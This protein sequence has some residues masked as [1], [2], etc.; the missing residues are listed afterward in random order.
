MSKIRRPSKIVPSAE[1][2]GPKA[3][4]K[5][6]IIEKINKAW[7][8]PRHIKNKPAPY[9]LALTKKR[10]PFTGALLGEIFYLEYLE[11]STPGGI[12]TPSLRFRRTVWPRL[13]G[14]K[15]PWC[16]EEPCLLVLSCNW[17]VTQTCTRAAQ[18]TAQF[19]PWVGL[20]ARWH[21]CVNGLA[22]GDPRAL[23]GRA[24]SSGFQI[25]YKSNWKII[26]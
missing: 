10:A 18:F 6:I 25:N 17:N 24:R 15:R 1:P 5:P 2:S 9:Y 14:R 19:F 11:K 21:S 20:R 4:P 23:C 26:A 8:I 16:Y 12:R 7:T 3:R 13:R 22:F